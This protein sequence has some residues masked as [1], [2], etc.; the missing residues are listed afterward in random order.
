MKAIFT[1]G[2]LV[3]LFGF[4]QAQRTVSLKLVGDNNVPLKAEEVGDIKV[5]WYG[6]DGIDVIYTET[7]PDPS[8]VEGLINLELGT[9]ANNTAYTEA[10]NAY[11]RNQ[12]PASETSIKV[13]VEVSLTNG[14]LLNFDKEINLND[15]LPVIKVINDQSVVILP[16]QINLV[17]GNRDVYINGREM[18]MKEDTSD[19]LLSHVDPRGMNIYGGANQTAQFS[20]DGIYVRKEEDYAKYLFGTGVE[21]K[22]TTYNTFYGLSGGNVLNL[23]NNDHFNFSTNEFSLGRSSNK[24]WFFN[25][26]GGGFNPSAGRT[27]EFTSDFFGIKDDITKRESRL[28]YNG[29]SGFH[30]NQVRFN[31]GISSSGSPL[32]QFLNSA[33]KLLYNMSPNT[34][35]VTDITNHNPDGNFTYRITSLS[36]TAGKNPY[37][38]ITQNG[39]PPGAGMYYNS[40]NVPV[41]FASVKNFRMD[42]PDLAD[43]DIVYASLEGPEAAAYCRGKGQL[44]QG[45]QFIPFPDHF[46]FV[47]SPDD[48]TIQLTPRSAKSR[49]LAVTEITKEGFRIEELMEGAGNYE[50]FWEVKG[51][52][53]GFEDYQVI[54]PKSE[55][56][57]VPFKRQEMNKE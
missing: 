15:P 23:S 47:C 50:F 24:F 30:N 55:V 53:K 33:G 26:S 38:Y 8:V 19:I 54:R 13:N 52:R 16:A 48:L 9:G 2:L 29:I 35:G 17:D 41:L 40:N 46:K 5:S 57:P 20:S 27:H 12:V 11:F 7:F 3:L 56:M 14:K 25:Q 42:H 37:V 32:F 31:L 22:N 51:T 34:D 18:F 49:G 1:F 21:L 43:Q 4:T 39:G 45:K 28:F 36:G 44:T 10:V 6:Q